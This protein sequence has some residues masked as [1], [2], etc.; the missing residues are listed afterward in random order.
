MAASQPVVVSCASMGN[1]T[2]VAGVSGLVIRVNRLLL[3]P[4]SAVTFQFLDGATGLT[5]IMSIAANQVFYLE[6]GTPDALF[7]TSPGNGFILA[8]GG[9]VQVSGAIWFLQG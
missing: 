1:N 9:A 3:V 2:L 8:L 5:G 4:A 7:F 6:P